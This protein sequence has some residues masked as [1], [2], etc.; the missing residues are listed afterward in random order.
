MFFLSRL[1]NKQGLADSQKP[2]ELISPNMTG[3]E[4]II[5]RE[6]G[7][8]EKRWKTQSVERRRGTVFFFLSTSTLTSSL[9]NLNNNKK[10]NS[11]VRLLLPL[12]AL[13]LGD[14]AAQLHFTGLP[15]KQ[16]VRAAEPDAAVVDREER[17]RRESLCG[18]WSGGDARSFD[19]GLSPPPRRSWIFGE[20]RETVAPLPS[21]DL[22]L[23]PSFS[24]L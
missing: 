12:H 23:L 21:F 9:L 22:F 5:W 17:K 7:R 19:V 18:C 4:I 10:K 8:K 6:K 3:G 13:R 15:R 24:S 2:A 1:Q 11:H 20:G 14:P 16:R